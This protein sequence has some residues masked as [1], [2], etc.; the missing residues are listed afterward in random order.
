[1]VGGGVRCKFEGGKLGKGYLH[2]GYWE[3]GGWGRWRMGWG[4]GGR[5]QTT[6]GSGNKD[7]ILG[8]GGWGWGQKGKP[9]EQLGIHVSEVGGGLGEPGENQG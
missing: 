3:P 2:T 4:R 8:V 5:K 1:M 9:E 7:Q 6:K